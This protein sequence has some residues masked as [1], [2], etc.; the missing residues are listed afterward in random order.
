MALTLSTD[1]QQA[2]SAYKNISM[3]DFLDALDRVD[4]AQCPMMAMAPNEMALGSTEF[5]KNV[6]SFDAPKGARG[7]ADGEAAASANV[8]NHAANVRKI[9]NIAQ[10]FREQ[11]GVGWIAQNVPKVA[12]A[13]DQLA[14]AKTKAAIQLKRQM[15]VAMC[16]LDQTAVSDAGASLGAIGA[17]YLKL[18]ASANAYAGASAFAY[19]KPSDIHYAPANAVVTG[20]MSAVHNRALWKTISLALRTAAQQGGDYTLLCGLSLRQAISDLTNPV[21]TNAAAG[22][23]GTAALV[24]NA[25]EQVRVLLR[26][27]QDTT[28]GATI[29]V[30]QTDFGR[31][32][33]KETDYIGNTTVTSTGGALTAWASSSAERIQAAFS[34]NTKAGLIVRRGNVFKRWGVPVYSEEIAPNGG[35]KS[36]DTK[37]LMAWGVRNP[38]LAGHLNLT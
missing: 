3:E 23:T 9:G 8:T 33:V 14:Y 19:G 17:G 26:N 20:A 22:A 31:F 5:S 32:L 28:L 24:S 29:D 12:G 37:A 27:E 11:F 15:E 30:I 38:I 16:S 35:G 13:K 25:A 36:L 7:V 1:L 6:D 34:V 2:T 18:T 4:P 21:T 10:G